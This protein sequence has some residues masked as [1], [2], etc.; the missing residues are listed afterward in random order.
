MLSHKY[1]KYNKFSVI[2]L[3]PSVSSAVA[4][5]SSRVLPRLAWWRLSVFGTCSEKQ[6][7]VPYSVPPVFQLHTQRFYFSCLLQ[8]LI[9]PWT[10]SM[11]QLC[12]SVVLKHIAHIKNG[13][14]FAVC[15][16]CLVLYCVYF[17]LYMFICICIFV[18]SQQKDKRFW[19]R[20]MDYLL[21][22]GPETSV[23]LFVL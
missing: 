10:V 3:W 13:I 14:R 21:P 20:Y 11:C 17:I 1:I 18:A 4:K 16:I 2:H 9:F 19:V 8:W 23:F 22:F 15:V 6:F 12:F 5:C 7:V